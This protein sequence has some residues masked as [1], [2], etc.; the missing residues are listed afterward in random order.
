MAVKL[1]EPEFVYMNGKLTKWAD[2]TLH[3]GTEA[4]TR[5]L[6]VFEGLKGY[7]QKDGSFG[8]VF[9][10]RHYERL[11]RSAKLMHL[12]CPWSYGEYE[13]AV[14]E[15]LGAL[16]TKEQ[17]MWARV[18]LFGVEG[19]WGVGTK[20]DMVVT[21]YNQRKEQPAP[22]KI[23]ISTWQRSGDNALP[24]RVKAGAN[25]EVG[26]L[27]RIEG[28][29]LGYSDMILLNS[30]GRVSEATA[31]CVV[32][33]RDGVV[34]TTPHYEGSLESVTLDFVAEIAKSLGYEFVVR[35]IDRT[36]LMIADELALVG[37]LAELVPV[38]EVD[39]FQLNPNGKIIT[40]I[41]KRFF[42][43]VRGEDNSLDAEF[44]FVPNDQIRS[45]D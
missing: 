11:L 9:M 40:A 19:H 36:E 3:I 37:S 35:P 2:A 39:G 20:S 21:A 23:G 26:R 15:L 43:I 4:V 31:S 33:V 10:R 18:T 41:R 22:I 42:A 7:W 14:H 44:S 38:E 5:S 25:Y 16:L 8:I 29:R 17:D 24:Y 27:A 30:A 12:P 32:M 34:Y 45:L 6:N 28:A 13:S 1:Q